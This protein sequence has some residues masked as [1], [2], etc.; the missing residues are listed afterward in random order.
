[1]ISSFTRAT[2]RS[3]ISACP[4]S[5]SQQH[6]KKVVKAMTS[7][8]RQELLIDRDGCFRRG[9]TPVFASS[10]DFEPDDDHHTGFEQSIDAINGYANRNTLLDLG[11]VPS[12]G[13]EGKF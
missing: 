13:E 1:M 12:G 11:K 6:N 4:G 9:F 10:G 2:M 5:Q 8:T 7:R 3:I